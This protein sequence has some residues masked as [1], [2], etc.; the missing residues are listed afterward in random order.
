MDAYDD[1]VNKNITLHS[2]ADLENM[3]LT[4]LN[5]VHVDSSNGLYLCVLFRKH[6][7][8]TLRYR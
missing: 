1:M 5:Y 8:G 3:I 4:N 2:D 7:Y 6:T